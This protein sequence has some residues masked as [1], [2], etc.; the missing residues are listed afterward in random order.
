[1]TSAESRSHGAGVRARIDAVGGR[2]RSIR[3]DGLIFDLGAIT[4]LPTYTRICALIDELGIADHLHRVVPVIDIPRAGRI[5]R[6]DLA[7]P[8][9]RRIEISKACCV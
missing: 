7:H 4:M 2:S 1:M 9:M 3:R 8:L 6:L 5:H